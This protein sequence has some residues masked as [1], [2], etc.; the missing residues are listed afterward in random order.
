MRTLIIL[1]FLTTSA[2]ASNIG[3]VTSRAKLHEL[4]RKYRDSHQIVEY[5]FTPWCVYCPRQSA[6][7]ENLA[8]ENPHVL[9]LKLNGDVF[10]RAGVVSYPTVIINGRYNVGVT[11]QAVLQSQ[12]KPADTLRRRTGKS[13]SRP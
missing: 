12:L 5:H 1:L 2:A 4:Y 11:Q 6:I 3:E 7:L 8:R 13:T 10:K 9:F